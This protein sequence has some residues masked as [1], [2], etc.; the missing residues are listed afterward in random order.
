MTKRSQA[1]LAMA[2]LTLAVPL[3]AACAS[4][5]TTAGASTTSPTIA[6][7]AVL[8]TAGTPRTAMAGSAPVVPPPTAPCPTV[9]AVV[10]P[11]TD[12]T[13]HMRVGGTLTVVLDSP[14]PHTEYWSVRSVAGSSARVSSASTTA[15]GSLR[16]TVLAAAPGRT[17]INTSAPGPASAPGRSLTLVIAVAE[18]W[19]AS[20]G[21]TPQPR[22]G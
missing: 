22:K 7:T 16:L 1:A 17:L 3:L 21:W 8:A 11:E 19:A 5:T 6:A 14:Y 13:L 10:R 2:A 15:G 12:C 20:T 9:N 4:A 18:A